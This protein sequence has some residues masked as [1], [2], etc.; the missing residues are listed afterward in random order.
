M[1]PSHTSSWTSSTYCTGGTSG[2]RKTPIAQTN[3]NENWSDL[4]GWSFGQIIY[5]NLIQLE[6]IMIPET[7][8]S[9]Y[10]AEI[11]DHV[12]LTVPSGIHQWFVEIKRDS[13]SD[14]GGVYLKKGL[15]EFFESYSITSGNFLTFKYEGHSHFNVL[16]FGMSGGEIDYSSFDNHAGETSR[17]AETIDQQ[18]N[19]DVVEVS[20]L[21][22]KHRL[23]MTRG[24][25][26]TQERAFE[27]NM[28][29]ESP[30]KYPF[31][32]VGLQS[33]YIF[34]KYLPVP[35]TFEGKEVLGKM[36]NMRL[37]VVPNDGRSWVVHSS[38]PRQ[39]H[40]IRFSRGVAKFLRDNNLREGD[41][42]VFEWVTKKKAC[43][44]E[45]ARVH[46]FRS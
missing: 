34:H 46:I 24:G 31:Y 10:G 28:S 17:R 21:P 40:V 16:I 27:V 43:V 29:F 45:Y 30:E 7:F 38:G 4:G 32:T 36:D 22:R 33:S 18:E 15:R 8:V 11:S 35:A 14:D 44:Y 9:K 1:N 3:S 2:E 26:R 20:G 39:G 42:C 41:V 23:S 19:I 6:E 5:N 25:L 37:E 13:N 12:V